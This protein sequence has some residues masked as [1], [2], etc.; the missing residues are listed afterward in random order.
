MASAHT[1]IVADDTMSM[2]FLQLLL[3]AA[4]NIY[5]NPSKISMLCCRR[6]KTYNLNIHLQVMRIWNSTRISI[7]ISTNADVKKM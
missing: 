7:R 3:R 4:V 5:I 6:C 2:L 1:Y